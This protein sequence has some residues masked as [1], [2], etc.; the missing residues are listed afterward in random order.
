MDTDGDNKPEWLTL[1]ASPKA[2]K[3]TRYCPIII[4]NKRDAAAIRRK[5]FIRVTKSITVPLLSSTNL[6]DS[7]ENTI[8]YS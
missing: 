3:V 5:V 6:K 1:D 7:S 4:N 8:L 2:D